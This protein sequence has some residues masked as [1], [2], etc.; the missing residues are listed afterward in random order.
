MN[1]RIANL[2]K[3]L[4]AYPEAAQIISLAASQSNIVNLGYPKILAKIFDERFGK[5]AFTIA[6]WMKELHVPGDTDW[7]NKIGRRPGSWMADGDLKKCLG[8]F[9]AAQTAIDKGA[10]AIYVKYKRENDFGVMDSELSLTSDD[11]RETQQY[12]ISEMTEEI[13]G[14][15]FFYY[16]IGRDILSGKLTNLAPY[17]KLSFREALDKFNEKKVFQDQKPFK[18][19]PDGWR[20]INVGNKCELIGGKMQNCGSAGVMGSDP[21]RTM[22]ALFDTS[23]NPHVLL[24]HSPNEKRISGVEGIGGSTIKDKYSDYVMDLVDMLGADYDIGK[25][26]TKIL[27]L[28]T[29]LRGV[30]KDLTRITDDLY[31]EIFSFHDESGRFYYTDSFNVMSADDVEKIKNFL[32]TNMDYDTSYGSKIRGTGLSI[33]ATEEDLK[34]LPGLLSVV[35]SRY[36]NHDIFQSLVGVRYQR[37]NDFKTKG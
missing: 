36:Q 25:S 1:P 2:V 8:L 3:A 22:Y 9:N 34:T 6:R 24:T 12:L 28:K 11:L 19:Y 33:Y 5:N 26:Q 20:W 35:F 14:D 29:S 10:P 13:V 21:D 18:V 31:S 4:N 7:L 16:S 37:L 30:T 17:K 32:N 23:D 15:L 27:N